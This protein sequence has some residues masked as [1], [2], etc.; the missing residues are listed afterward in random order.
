MEQMR[1][2]ILANPHIPHEVKEFYK[3]LAIKREAGELTIL[4]KLDYI[5]KISEFRNFYCFLQLRRRVYRKRR[6][7]IG[8]IW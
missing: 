7:N 4:S 2:A 1:A 6:R 3:E 8:T 5:A